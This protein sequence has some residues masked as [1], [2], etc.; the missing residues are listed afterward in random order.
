LKPS[1]KTVWIIFLDGFLQ[2]LDSFKPSRVLK[3]FVAIK[4]KKTKS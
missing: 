4:S 3:I 1:E 2:F